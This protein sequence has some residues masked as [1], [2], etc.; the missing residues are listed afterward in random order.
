MSHTVTAGKAADRPTCPVG[1]P[2]D[3]A[4][5][6]AS[7]W[8]SGVVE[9]AGRV[10]PEFT[11]LT[12]VLA[13]IRIA[14][15]GNRRRLAHL[16]QDRWRRT[17]R[18]CLYRSRRNLLYRANRCTWDL[19]NGESRRCCICIRIRNRHLHRRGRTFK[20]RRFQ[21]IEVGGELSAS[22]QPGD[23]QQNK[24][25][26]DRTSHISSPSVT[27]H[28][29]FN[30]SCCRQRAAF[31]WLL[32]GSAS[33]RSLRGSNSARIHQTRRRAGLPIASAREAFVR[34][35]SGF[36][37]PQLGALIPAVF[38][39]LTAASASLTWSRALLAIATNSSMSSMV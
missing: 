19:G 7:V 37:A 15:A 29:N 20:P 14:I 23:K 3:M 18:T 34:K 39:A 24:E 36:A 28:Q 13:A 9:A 5:E 16:S 6:D 1:P 8:Y 22:Q 2:P 38:H 33:R 31:G 11:T 4:D 32:R 35:S 17:S 25:S 10:R 12:S 26:E 21:A 27:T 30:R